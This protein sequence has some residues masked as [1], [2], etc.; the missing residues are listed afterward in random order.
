MVI[1]PGP[2]PRCPTCEVKAILLPPEVRIRL[3]LPLQDRCGYVG[4]KGS[5]CPVADR[6][7]SYYACPRCITGTRIDDR[8]MNPVFRKNKHGTAKSC[9]PGHTEWVDGAEYDVPKAERVLPYFD[10]LG[11]DQGTSSSSYR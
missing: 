6:D 4:L 9:H 3:K 11:L 5:R 7:K 8:Y 1:A 2:A 10:F